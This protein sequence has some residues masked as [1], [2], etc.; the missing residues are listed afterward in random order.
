[1]TES[2]NRGSRD[3]ALLLIAYDTLFGRR[4]LATL[5]IQDI[6]FIEKYNILKASIPIRRSKVDQFG[7]GR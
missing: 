3:R 5:L 1:M 7:Q 4:K 2:G 6:K